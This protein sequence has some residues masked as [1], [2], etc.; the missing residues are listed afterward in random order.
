MRTLLLAAAML[1]L[2]ACAGT[3]GTVAAGP[4]SVCSDIAKI[5]ATVAATFDSQ[6]PSSALGV[7]W[8]DVKAGC[9]TAA[10]VA[11]SP[12]WTGMVW[13]ELKAIIP[14]VLPSVLPLLI[15]LI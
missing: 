6:N 12:D 5:P 9:N 11:A 10:S 3:T 7:L 13:G 8:A 2:A 14:A 1:G 15:G 4:A